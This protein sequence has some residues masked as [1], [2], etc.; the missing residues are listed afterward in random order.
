MCLP[1]EPWSAEEVQRWEEGRKK[2]AAIMG[3]DSESFSEREV[4]EALRYLLPSQ[5]SASDAQPL[6]KVTCC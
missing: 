3:A 2:L 6:L 1:P 4:A 5:L